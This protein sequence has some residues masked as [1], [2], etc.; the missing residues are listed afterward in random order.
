MNTLLTSPSSSPL[1]SWTNFLQVLLFLAFVALFAY[2]TSEIQDL[3]IS[4]YTSSR[5]A[6]FRG[7]ERGFNSSPATG[8]RNASFPGRI[9]G[10]PRYGQGFV[11]IYNAVAKCGSRSLLSTFNHLYSSRHL[12]IDVT[13]VTSVP[14]NSNFSFLKNRVESMKTP[15][16]V[17]GHLPFKDYDRDDVVYINMIRNPLERLISLYYFNLYGDA[18]GFRNKELDEKRKGKNF[19]SLEEL[20]RTT[21]FPKRCNYLWS[22]AG[23]KEA[24]GD[25]EIA[26]ALAKRNILNNFL[27]IGLTEEYE[28]SVAIFENLLPHLIDG[29]SSAYREIKIERCEMYATLNKTTPSNETMALLMKNDKY[30]KYEFEIYYFV[31]QLFNQTK[32]ALLNQLRK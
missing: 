26:V 15:G 25:P 10:I 29:V 12:H 24:K 4:R 14:K 8:Y 3:D 5:Y 11:V 23:E 18:G 28:T 9:Y 2:C 13:H 31:R 20:A 30:L 17:A 32:A 21:G 16:F 1:L 27:F 7:P 22:F 6:N 19:K